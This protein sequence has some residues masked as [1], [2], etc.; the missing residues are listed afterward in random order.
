MQPR[1]DIEQLLDD[2]Q[3]GRV[4]PVQV[5]EHDQHRIALRSGAHQAADGVDEDPLP[6]R[7][8]EVGKTWV[9]LG[10]LAEDLVHDGR[11][12]AERRFI[13]LDLGGSQRFHGVLAGLPIEQLRHELADEVVREC[14]CV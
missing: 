6:P 2:G 5:V 11:P 8:R 14:R 13:G 9:V 10:A 3:A 7:R 4:G 12:G 1:Q